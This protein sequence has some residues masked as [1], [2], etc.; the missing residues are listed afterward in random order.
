MGKTRKI[1]Q[2]A[3]PRLRVVERQQKEEEENLLKEAGTD[4][5]MKP[6][7]WLDAAAKKEWRRVLP[8]LLKLEIVGNLDLSDVAGYCNAFSKFQKAVKE[9]NGQPL[10]IDTDKGPRENP[11]ISA[12]VKYGTEMRRFADLCG[13]TVNSRLKAATVKLKK[14]DE[15][16]EDRFGVI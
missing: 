6:P 15:T 12:Q 10:T 13:M 4:E 3:K 16:I 9:L 14:Q 11:L 5:I 2:G 1:I 7:A 8:Q